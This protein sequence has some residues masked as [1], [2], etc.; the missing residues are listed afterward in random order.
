MADNEEAC[1]IIE[2]NM[3]IIEGETMIIS[4]SACG[5]AG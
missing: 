3:T 1:C 2:A 5:G 4:S